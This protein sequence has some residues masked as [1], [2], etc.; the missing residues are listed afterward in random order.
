[1]GIGHLR[2]Y[3]GQTAW[4]KSGHL[5]TILGLFTYLTLCHFA[6]LL[7]STP[8]LSEILLPAILELSRHSL[9][10]LFYLLLIFYAGWSLGLVGAI[11]LL[12]TSAIAMLLRTFLISPN[13]S[14]ALLET[15]VTLIISGLGIAVV[16]AYRQNKEGQRKLE[17]VMKDLETSRQNLNDLL[18]NASD[19]I[20]VHDTEGRITFAN[21]ACE[22]L[23]G[24]P[25]SELVGKN[26]EELFGQEARVLAKQSRDKL[27]RGEVLEQRY[28]QILTRKDG[29][30]AIAQLATRVI[31]SDGKPQ[32]FQNMARDVTEERRLRD[33]LQF[34]LK[35]ILK[36]Q[37]EERKR[38]ACELHDDT[39][40][41]ILLLAHGLDN[42]ASRAAT[43]LPEELR[44]EVDRLYEL[45]HQIYQGI[46]RYA[47]AL[48]P[49]I[50][51]D[52][53]LIPAVKWLA[54]E[55]QKF[56]GIEVRVQTAAIPPLS[57]ETQ[58]IL[59]RVIQEALNNI[60]RHSGASQA[61]ISMERGENEVVITVSDN[62]RG[63][64]LPSQLSDFASQ[65]KLGL[66]GMAE[67][68]RLIDGRLEVISQKGKGTKIVVRIPA[69]FYAKGTS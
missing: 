39:S 5:L 36:A 56:T 69:K 53:G 45:S 60:Q 29:S 47:Q 43:Y 9:E 31:Y 40:Q 35:E 59:F 24:Y 58:L 8:I 22:K 52:L 48:R 65:G 3:R 19:A 33:N 46:K 2:R 6:E 25:V 38:L 62:G 64:E 57:P 23:T 28:E 51:D 13:F 17:Q 44:N 10:R 7:A 42:L 55:T 34:Y 30:E 11:A 14:D 63:F 68:I 21:K 20:W 4:L 26:V 37:E 41:Q 12:A 66:T 1:M 61:N 67:R 27:M 18:E 15:C 50:L 32:A 54:E 49:R 16:A